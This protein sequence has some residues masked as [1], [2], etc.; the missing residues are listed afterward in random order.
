MLEAKSLLKASV[1]PSLIQNPSPGSLQS[2]R[3]ALHV[4]EDGSACCV[5]IASGCNVYKLKVPSEDALVSEGKD[6]LLIP[7]HTQITDSVLVNRCP[8]R[9]EI[10]SIILAETDST[11]HLILGS[12][13]SYGHLIVSKLDISGKN[14]DKITYSVLPQD[15]GVGE[16]SWAGV[17]FSPSHWSMAAVARSFSKSIDIYDQ[18]IHLRTLRTLWYPSSLNFVQNLGS[19]GGGNSI[20]AVTE[21]CQLT[22]WDLRIKENGGCL[23]RICGSIGDIFYAVCS[24]SRDNIAVGG[25]D[26]TVTIYDPRR[27][28]ALSRWVNCSKYEITGLSFSSVDPDYIYIQGMDYE[29]SCGQW[30]KSKKAFTFRGD[31]NWLGFNK[32]PGKDVLGGWCDSGSIFVADVVER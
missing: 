15:C 28:S 21:G 12:V 26:R 30:K 22:I 4:D 8:H 29:V 7:F 27:W 32:C 6:N 16:G 10:Q 19:N 3:L 13:D 24:S 5:Y 23:Q 14:V 25:A 31:S 9:S 1:P 17:C 2:T 11:G 20:L 18:D